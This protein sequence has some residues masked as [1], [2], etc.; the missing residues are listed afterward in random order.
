MPCFSCGARQTDPVRGA[1][2]WKRGVRRETQVLIC[3]DCQR[4]H[5]LDLDT[6]AACGSAALICRLGEVECRSCGSVRLARS[7]RPVPAGNA[8]APG[9]PDVPDA[10][11]LADEVQAALERVLGRT[12]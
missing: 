11:G 4:A 1:S 12:R 7:G 5:D 10:S 9:A 2:P 8:A 3:P 6:C